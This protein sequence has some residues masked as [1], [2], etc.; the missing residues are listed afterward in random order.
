MSEDNYEYGGYPESRGSK[1]VKG[2]LKGLVAFFVIAVYAALAWRMFSAR[3]PS[4]L[5]Q[6]VWTEEAIEARGSDPDSFSLWSSDSRVW[7]VD[8]HT[9]KDDGAFSVENVIYTDSLSLLQVSVRYNNST[10]KTLV[11]EY[12][13]SEK[14]EGEPFVY[15]LEDNAGKIYSDYVYT[16]SAASLYNYRVLIF[17]D[18]DLSDLTKLNLNAYYVGDVDLSSS[19]FR[20]IPFYRTDYPLSAFPEKG[21]YLTYTAYEDVTSA[22]DAQNDAETSYKTYTEYVLYPL[23]AFDPGTVPSSPA[24]GLLTPVSYIVKGNS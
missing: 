9:N 1:I 24:E 5:R 4:F 13:L 12:G 3:T 20:E 15:M 14:P 17:K 7:C 22:K 16:A 23:K 10:L 18:V 2:V 8:P 19:P 6:Y 21:G 11:S